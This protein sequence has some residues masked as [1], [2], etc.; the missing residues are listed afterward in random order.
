M[1]YDFE[2]EIYAEERGLLL[3]SSAADGEGRG[4][5]FR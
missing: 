5:Y 3:L 1:G 2:D 4:V